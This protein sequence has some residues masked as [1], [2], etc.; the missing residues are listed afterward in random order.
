VKKVI[1][2][3]I[4]SAHKDI[5]QAY[6]LVTLCTKNGIEFFGKMKNGK[7]EPNRSGKIAQEI[8]EAIPEYNNEIKLDDYVIMPNHLHG[9]I[10]YTCYRSEKQILNALEKSINTINEFRKFVKE[11]VQKT[12]SRIKFGWAEKFN[13]YHIKD[14]NELY[15]MRYY[16]EKEVLKWEFDSENAKNKLYNTGSKK[17]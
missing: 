11:Q 7:L 3:K 6:F 1:N 12:N 13:I 8:W 2:K 5:S 16:I 15:D 9:I 4:K 17:K 10:S 14:E